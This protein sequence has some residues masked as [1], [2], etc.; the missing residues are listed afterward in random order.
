[1]QGWTD[2]GNEFKEVGYGM[3]IAFIPKMKMS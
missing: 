3:A 1:M 2:N